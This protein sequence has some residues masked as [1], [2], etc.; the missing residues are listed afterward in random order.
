[1]RHNDNDKK[2]TSWIVDSNYN[3][4]LETTHANHA[5]IQE[6]THDFRYHAKQLGKGLFHFLHPGVYIAL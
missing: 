2:S 6:T 1:M 4:V 5:S 3:T